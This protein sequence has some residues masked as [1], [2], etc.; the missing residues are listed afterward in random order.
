MGKKNNP[1]CYIESAPQQDEDTELTDAI[2]AYLSAYD[3]ES[4]QE[5][6]TRHAP[7]NHSRAR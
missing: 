5:T 3:E 7:E 4:A 2:E 6:T 1:P